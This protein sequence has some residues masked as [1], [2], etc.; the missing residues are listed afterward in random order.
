MNIAC[1]NYELYIDEY[2]LGAHHKDMRRHLGSWVGGRIGL[3]VYDVVN[4]VHYLLQ[5]VQMEKNEN[6]E[7]LVYE[8]SEVFEDSYAYENSDILNLHLMRAPNQKTVRAS[9]PGGP[10]N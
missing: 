8:K 2:V 9:Q 3:M 5:F 4:G 10:K 7:A 6:H 1:K